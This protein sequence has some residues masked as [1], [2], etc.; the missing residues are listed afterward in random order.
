[1]SFYSVSKNK[2]KH[3]SKITDLITPFLIHTIV[4]TP[5]AN[6]HIMLEANVYKASRKMSSRAIPH[7]FGLLN[8][9]VSRKAGEES[10]E[11]LFQYGTRRSPV[12]AT[13]PTLTE[14]KH[15]KKKHQLTSTAVAFMIETE[16][17]TQNTEQKWHNFMCEC[18]LHY[19]FSLN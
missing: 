8:V 10:G 9:S 18:R 11:C 14:T 2:H 7:S 1:M 16:N 17:T 12:A 6:I 15:M 4:H 3:I 5:M 13:V 19:A